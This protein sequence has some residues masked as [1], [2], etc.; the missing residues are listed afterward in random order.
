M[1]SIKIIIL[2][3]SLLTIQAYLCDIEF[4]MACKKSLFT[5]QSAVDRLWVRLKPSLLQ[6]ILALNHCTTYQPLLLLLL[7]LL[8]LILLL[9]KYIVYAV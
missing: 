5:R 3:F 8:L 4:R 6:I 1:I 7:L 9:L 2:F